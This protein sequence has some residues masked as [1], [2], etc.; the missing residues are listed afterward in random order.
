MYDIYM[1]RLPVTPK[2]PSKK[3]ILSN[4]DKYRSTVPEIIDDVL[5]Y[6]TKHLEQPLEFDPLGERWGFIKRCADDLNTLHKTKKKKAERLVDG[7]RSAL[8]RSA[9]I[10]FNVHCDVNKIVDGTEGIYVPKKPKKR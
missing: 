2:T 10:I 5:A 6:N 9:R 8:T 7:L 1:K 3:R 4:I